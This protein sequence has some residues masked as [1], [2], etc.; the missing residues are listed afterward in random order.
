MQRV[1]ISFRK[2]D[3]RVMRELLYTRL[4]GEFGPEQVFKSGESIPP[5]TDYV[6]IL[7]AQARA[8]PVMLVL[9]GN[10][11]LHAQDPDGG[12]SLHRDNDWVR[13]E[14]RTAIE[15]GNRVI[16]VLLGD[17][18]LMPAAHELP[19]DIAAMASIQALRIAHSAVDA[20]LN[21]L[22]AVLH[23]NLPRMTKQPEPPAAD[24][25]NRLGPT[26][27]SG[28]V[29]GSVVTGEVRGAMVGR[30]A[31]GPVVGGDL[32][33]TT[34]NRGYGGTASAAGGAAGSVAAVLKALGKPFAKSAAWA[35]GHRITASISALVL[36]GGATVGAAVATNGISGKGSAVSGTVSTSVLASGTTLASIETASATG[37]AWWADGNVFVLEVPSTSAP[38][39]ADGTASP[40]ASTSSSPNPAAYDSDRFTFVTYS[41]TTGRRIASFAA[42][43]LSQ[44]PVCFDELQRTPQGIDVMLLAQ[45]VSGA[46]FNMTGSGDTLEFEGVN[47]ANGHRLWIGTLPYANDFSPSN[48]TCTQPSADVFQS[49][50]P[51]GQ[52]VLDEET[53]VP[54]LINLSTG[55]FAQ[56]PAKTA[57]LGRWLAEPST[58][59]E[60]D[61]PNSSSISLVDPSTGSIVHTILDSGTGITTDLESGDE[62]SQN[63]YGVIGADSGGDLDLVVGSRA[64]GINGQTV[65]YSLPSA[66][67]LWKSTISK[68]SAG[69]TGFEFW[70][71]DYDDPTVLILYSA[72]QPARGNV[73]ALDA[74]TGAKLWERGD[75]KM[76]GSTRG[77]TYMISDRGLVELDQ[78][79]GR[80]IRQDASVSTCPLVDDG[81]L[82]EVG[83][84]QGSYY[85]NTFVVG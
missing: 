32:H 85:Q 11:W 61:S 40:I 75:S 12:R 54:Y 68:T 69:T 14:I 60:A 35:G 22:V 28:T 43:N 56:K 24:G 53:G 41:L 16:P 71:L 76:C 10:G 38:A 58:A 73:V 52:F 46:E 84:K 29:H 80:Q 13:F 66:T 21:R 31:H 50:V 4:A 72:Q 79:T 63:S 17:D 7:H 59:T 33:Q 19:P 49:A 44:G 25:K 3:D 83:A 62:N 2:I 18:V 36:V 15:S 20:G 70:S 47:A 1:F 77:H 42:P 5:G 23:A 27:I 81:I 65:A 48:G 37:D 30:D 64:N 6:R 74:E 9:I 51:G 45:F 57:V 8:C 55:A 26:D 39:D 34:V 67:I 82:D 78:N